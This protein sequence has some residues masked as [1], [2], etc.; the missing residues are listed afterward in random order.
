ME[1]CDDSSEDYANSLSSLSDLEEEE[2][3][4]KNCQ[5]EADSRPSSEGNFHANEGANIF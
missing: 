1:E 2:E 3:D 5:Y 4:E